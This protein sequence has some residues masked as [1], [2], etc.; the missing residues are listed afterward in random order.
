MLAAAAVEQWEESSGQLTGYWLLKLA[1]ALLLFCVCL[2]ARISRKRVR[3]LQN[4][5]HM[6]PVALQYV[7]YLRC[8]E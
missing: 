4:F 1:V 8:C 5:L 7:M 3:A 2:S 6:L